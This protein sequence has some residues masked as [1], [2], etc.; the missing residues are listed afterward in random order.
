MPRRNSNHEEFC[1]T[2][3]QI[4][5]EL[6]KLLRKT[7]ACNKCKEC[8]NCQRAEY[9]DFEIKRKGFYSLNI[10]T[11]DWKK[12]YQGCLKRLIISPVF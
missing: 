6:D 5:Y 12:R 11:E 8:I 2:R 7:I 3:E 10:I 9:I 1:F 4:E